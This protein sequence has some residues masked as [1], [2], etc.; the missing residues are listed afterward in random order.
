[1]PALFTNPFINTN[2]EAAQPIA[3]VQPQPGAPGPTPAGNIPPPN[4][5]Q[6]QQPAPTVPVASDQS[7]AP[8]V[9]P[10][11]DSPLAEFANMWDT[12]PTDPDAPAPVDHT[13][14]QADLDKALANVDFTANIPPETMVLAQSGEEGSGAAFATVLNA[15]VKQSFAQSTLAQQKLTEQ[16]VARAV[17]KTEATIPDLVRASQTSAHL[18]NS[19]P[20]F[21]DPAIKPVI[22]ATR[23]TLLQNNPDS[24][25]EQITE[26]VENYLVAMGKMFAPQTPANDNSGEGN[27]DWSTFA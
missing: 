19:N 5:G 24:T 22:D 4:T 12:V 17:A 13:I 21:S 3:P 1:M 26:M 25:P 20:L 15:V 9:T 27:T 14:K 23:H 2:A 6:P 16:A 18:K 10:V 8:V 7:T 11:D